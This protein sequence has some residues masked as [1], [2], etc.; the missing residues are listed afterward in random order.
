MSK[1]IRTKIF[2]SL[3]LTLT[4][5]SVITVASNQMLVKASAGEQSNWKQIGGYWH[6]FDES[7]N[8]VIGWVKD[9]QDWYYLG[10]DGIMKTGWI[11]DG[12]N[13]YYCW[14]T[15]QLATNTNIAGY[16]VNS[17]GAWQQSVVDS[18]LTE[19]LKKYLVYGTS[20]YKGIKV[21]EFNSI[22][23][24][25]ADGLLSKEDAISKL[26]KMKWSEE[27]NT[28]DYNYNGIGD[29]SVFAANIEKFNVEQGK[30]A[31]EIVAEYRSRIRPSTFAN[32][33]VYKNADNSI[34]IT[35]INCSLSTSN[36]GK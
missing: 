19:Q 11:Q 14:S 8:S 33:I 6:Y 16:Y 21:N 24:Q 27:T 25:V 12:G 28:I 5:A 34:T 15:G 20:T 17:S 4:M 36:I 32:L 18:E 1:K 7:G 22:M 2:K 31:K 30:T 26:T 23:T 9:G 10:N 3:A 13:W 35:S 29:V